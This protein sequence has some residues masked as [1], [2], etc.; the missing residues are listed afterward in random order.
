MLVKGRRLSLIDPRL[1]VALRRCDCIAFVVRFASLSR[2]LNNPA[3]H[4]PSG[5]FATNLPKNLSE[6]GSE[7]GHPSPPR[8]HHDIFFRWTPLVEPFSL[9]EAFSDVT[10]SERLLGKAEQMMPGRVSDLHS[11]CRVL[12]AAKHSIRDHAER[13]YRR[14][15]GDPHTDDDSHGLWL[16]QSLQVKKRKDVSLEKVQAQ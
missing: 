2:S 16:A 3:G 9:D 15:N 1:R 4:S 11:P 5:E 13:G 14:R 6:H 10:G 7:H 12:L 8:P